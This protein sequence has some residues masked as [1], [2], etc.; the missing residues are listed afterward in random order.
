[1]PATVKIVWKYIQVVV[2]TLQTIVE[3][4]AVL[5]KYN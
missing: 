3:L 1:M 4:S 5:D 2:S